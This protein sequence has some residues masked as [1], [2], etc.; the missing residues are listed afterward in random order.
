MSENKDEK[1]QEVVIFSPA[2]KIKEKANYLINEVAIV[3]V[4]DIIAKTQNPAMFKEGQIQ[5][6]DITD[7]NMQNPQ[8]GGQ[9]KCTA[10]IPTFITFG[11]N[12]GVSYVNT[13]N[14]LPTLNK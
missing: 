1:K 9:S 10:F 8:F 14:Y 7:D 11:S 3:S 13:T 6:I 4:A 2:P 5:I 12:S